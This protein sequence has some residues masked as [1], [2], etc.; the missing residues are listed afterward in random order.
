MELIIKSDKQQACILGAKIIAGVMRKKTSAVLGLATGSTPLKV[1]SELVRMH[2]EEGLSFKQTT[3]F[4]LDEYI[5]LPSDHP[6]SFRNEMHKNL[7]DKI[8]IPPES[9]N[10]PDGSA[11]DIPVMCAAY[12][13][14]IKS[15]GGIDLQLL[16]IGHD[17][18]LAFNE[19]GSSLNSRT[20]LKTLSQETL[21]ANSRFFGSIDKVPRH[22][23]TMG[24]G[25][26]MEANI[27]L[28]LAF[29]K[30]KA[31]AVF[32]M[33]EGAVSATWPASVLQFHQHAIVLVDEE[34]ASGLKRKQYYKDVYAGK[35]DWQMYE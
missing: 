1:Y 27:C 35:P 28:V 16:G 25:S 4:N 7:F 11:K 18:H 14:K 2:Q 31:E 20:R 15:V 24:L 6:C 19:P 21:E 29:G 3:S 23:V 34:A 13:E 33:V 17:G 8:D 9:I 30:D 12:D 32:Q 10:L 22:C 26:I 5:G